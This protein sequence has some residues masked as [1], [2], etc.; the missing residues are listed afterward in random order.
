MFIA[1]ITLFNL[2]KQGLFM[3]MNKNASSSDFSGLYKQAIERMP[4]HI[5]WKDK[6]FQYLSCNLLQ[7]HDAGLK[8][9]EEVIGKTDYD[10]FDQNTAD[11]IRKNDM[12]VITTGLPCVFEEPWFGHPNGGVVFLTQKI[13]LLS[14]H[15]EIIGLTGISFNITERKK[16]EEKMLSEKKVMEQTL[17]N[18][19]DNLPG[20]VYWK[21]KDSVYQGCNLAQAK[22]AGL[23]SQ[24]EIIGKTDYQMPWS[25]EADILRESDLMV[26]NSRETLT[27]EEASKLANSDQVSM[28]LS[29][30]TPLF[31]ESGDVVG[32]LGISFD[33][34]DRKKME[35][36]L[37]LAKEAAEAASHAKTEFIANMGHDIRT[38]LT[39]IIGMSHILE[40]EAS[41]PDEKEHANMIN[42]SGEQ[43]LGLLNGVLDLITVDASTE[44]TVLH[45]SFDVRKII[46]D[47]IELEHPAIAAR[48]LDIKSHVDESIP[49]YVVGDKM[50]LHRILL[51][52]IGNAIKFTKVGHVEINAHLCSIQNDQVKIE[53][54]V[55]D[56]GIGI[57]EELQ[58]K[59]FDRFFKVSPS[60]K[61]LYTGNGIGLHI[62]QKY[63]DLLGGEIR[64]ASSVGVGTSFNFV[65]PMKV[66]QKLEHEDNESTG[67]EP[68]SRQLKSEISTTP[69]CTPKSPKQLV[70][71][72]QFQVLL[73][74]DN[75]IALN[76]LIAMV[77]HFDAQVST[78]VSAELAFDLVKLQPFDLIITDVGL[79]GKQG[80]EL[81]AMIRVF[82]KEKGR[83]PVPIIGCTGHTAIELHQTY[84]DAGMNEV[85]TKPMTTEKMN[86]LMD[87]YGHPSVVESATPINV[88]KNKKASNQNNDI[89][90]NKKNASPTAGGALGPDLPDTEDQ[91]FEIN[92]YPL[93][94]LQVG[95]EI[96]EDEAVARQIIKVVKNESIMPDLPDLLNAYRLNNWCEVERL[97][98]KMKGGAC[99][100]TVRLYY[101]LMYMER[102]K[103]AGHTRCLE[104]LYTQ[105]ID[106]INDTFVRLDAFSK[107]SME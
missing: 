55:K 101:A 60:Y 25:N 70:N 100:G 19:I 51:N 68:I 69:V 85:Y 103:K 94:D 27:R 98:H 7:A 106:T 6:N 50:K 14:D 48:Q 74:E 34:T 73:V 10:L 90:S 61:G 47:L 46:N 96:F 53:F 11:I 79:P 39:G 86:T 56:T 65:L 57:P 80:D 89:V 44:D 2:F 12:E 62:A 99:Y 33:I 18:I 4:V 81:T 40:E 9:V 59:V 37:H 84:M 58:D 102:Y 26:M 28:F 30:K 3:K 77:K 31:D 95:I 82:E 20:H 78:A 107:D 64:L 91:L 29:K 13:P 23:T 93:L 49:N 52:L 22:S 97:A 92:Q 24:N 17:A 43:L 16:V 36:E 67:D 66:G 105:M 5:Y 45:E 83:K 35:E 38:P 21:N 87:T 8:S 63:V 104:T 1:P 54:S 41:L 71:S 72:N 75:M 76:V 32:I 15:G 42:T 88:E